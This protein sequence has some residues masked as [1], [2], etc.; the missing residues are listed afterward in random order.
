MN[1]KRR[2][3]QFRVLWN[4]RLSGRTHFRWHEVL[5]VYCATPRF[6]FLDE[7][8]VGTAI[9]RCAAEGYDCLYLNFQ[10]SERV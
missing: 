8:V 2:K 5:I 10:L 4:D 1:V 3:V 7:T 9:R 6:P